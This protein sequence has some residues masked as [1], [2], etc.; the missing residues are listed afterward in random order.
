[1]LIFMIDISWLVIT[2]LP[3]TTLLH[4]ISSAKLPTTITTEYPSF[5][6][7]V[8]NTN[9]IQ[10]HTQHCYKAPDTFGPSQ[11]YTHYF[12]VHD[13]YGSTQ[14]LTQHYY[15]AS[16][17]FCPSQTHTHYYSTHDP[18]GPSQTQSINIQKFHLDFYIYPCYN[19]KQIIL[20]STSYIK[21]HHRFRMVFYGL[22]CALLPYISTAHYYYWINIILMAFFYFIE[23]S[24]FK[25]NDYSYFIVK[26]IIMTLTS[27]ITTHQGFRMVSYG[28]ACAPLPFISTAHYYW[29]II[30]I[31]MELFYFIKNSNFKINDYPYFIV[32][33][34]IMTFTSYITTHQ[35]F[36]MVFYG[37]ACALLP[38]IS[39][40]HYY[41]NI[42]IILMEL[43]CFIENSNLKINDYPYFI[44]TQIKLT[45]TSYITT[46]Q[47]FR[48]VSTHQGFRITTHKLLFQKII[49]YIAESE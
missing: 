6:S 17:T 8:I 24:N 38:Y 27:Y 29:N 49:R 2:F 22:A 15:K 40:A 23:Y 41:W 39:T 30:I 47:C 33:Q 28:L 13:Q 46:H 20:T 44:V 32:T 42:I 7:I 25:I 10:T 21:T 31:L 3:L 1:M 19:V 14:T 26:Q 9:S 11:I 36:R 18:F 45:L 34:I 12:L 37:L 16:D 35:G 48:M 5:N 43:F 4:T